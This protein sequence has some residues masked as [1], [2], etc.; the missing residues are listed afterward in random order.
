[1]PRRKNLVLPTCIVMF[2]A[3]VPAL[4][5]TYP[6]A[7]KVDLHA[8]KGEAVWFFRSCNNGRTGETVISAVGLNPSVSNRTSINIQVKNA[9]PGYQLVCELYFANSGKLP[10]SVKDITVTN[11]N[12]SNLFL[13][14]IVARGEKGK[15]LQPCGSKP[16]WGKNPSNLPPNC[17]SKIKLALTI[18]PKA[19]ENRRMDFVIRVR[20]EEKPDHDD[21]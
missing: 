6:A 11:P 12:S 13:S 2:L 21:R 16:G 10:I 18:G 7:A 8:G 1:M 20:L 19:E 15:V 14:A 5:S 9:Y 3:F 4:L 17:R